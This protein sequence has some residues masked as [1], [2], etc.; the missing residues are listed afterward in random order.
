[1]KVEE[2]V[3]LVESNKY[4]RRESILNDENPYLLTGPNNLLSKDKISNHPIIYSKYITNSN[5][6]DKLNDIFNRNKNYRK[7]LSIDIDDDNDNDAGD[8]DYEFQHGQRLIETEP[9]RLWPSTT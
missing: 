6:F 7:K 8:K 9:T 2:L 3:E 5:D 1:M 4:I